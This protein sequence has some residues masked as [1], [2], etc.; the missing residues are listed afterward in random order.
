VTASSD[1]AKVAYIL[2][3]AVATVLVIFAVTVLLVALF[4]HKSLGEGAAKFFTILLGAVIGALG[5]Y[6]GVR[7]KPGN[8]TGNGT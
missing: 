8:G 5:A 6:I 4:G 1:K 3:V 7:G 2:A